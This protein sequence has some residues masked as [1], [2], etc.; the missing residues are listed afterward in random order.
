MLSMDK[1]SSI[2]APRFLKE[3]TGFISASPIFI[4]FM[5]NLLKL[6]FDPNQIYR[7]GLTGVHHLVRLGQWVFEW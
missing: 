2:K 5:F 4:E 6:C 7:L 3:E 1:F